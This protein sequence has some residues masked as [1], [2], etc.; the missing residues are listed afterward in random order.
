MGLGSVK[1]NDGLYLSIAGGYIWN[2]KADK[3]DPDFAT[4][5]YTKAD[6]SVGTRQGAQYQ[7]LTGDIKTVYFKEH[8]EY[9]QSV[10]VKIVSEGESYILSIST[11][12]RYSQD[13][14]KALL[15][16][17][18][19]KPLFIKPYDFIADKQKKVG[20]EWVN[21]G[22]KK[23]Q[24]GI[25]FRQDG[26][27]LSLKY[28]GSPEYEGEWSNKKKVKR[29]FEDLTDWYVAEV[30]AKIIPKFEVDEDKVEETQSEAKTETKEKEVKKESEVKISP[31]KMKKAI[32]AYIEENYEDEEM[33]KL[34]KEDVLIWYQLVLDEDE[35]PFEGDSKEVNSED[36]DSQLEALMNK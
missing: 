29:Y 30:E 32:K 24:Q 27:K 36:I 26:E 18:L 35:L 11:N 19:D 4:Q 5:E 25:S 9:G 7:D 8:Q 12:N 22:E 3:S 10:N 17:D 2:R 15:L 33:P 1:K 20:N 21:T 31:V 13:T 14:M 34:K 23:R 28:P 16:M 6:K